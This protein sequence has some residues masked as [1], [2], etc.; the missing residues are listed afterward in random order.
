MINA[1]QIFPPFIRGAIERKDITV[2]LATRQKLQEI[3]STINDKHKLSC[4][5]DFTL[6]SSENSGH[7][8]TKE[9]EVV[10]MAINIVMEQ[11]PTLQ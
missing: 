7:T 2:L 1:I 10:K 9:L 5:H 8:V 3:L 4:I 6:R 11:S